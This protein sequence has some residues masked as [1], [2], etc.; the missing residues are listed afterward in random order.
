MS[1]SLTAE[2]ADQYVRRMIAGEVDYVLEAEPDW[3]KVD[4]RDVGAD[5]LFDG[6]SRKLIAAALAKLAK[7]L[8]A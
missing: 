3:M 6:P 8:R 1:R 4:Y 2:E 5:D 7:K